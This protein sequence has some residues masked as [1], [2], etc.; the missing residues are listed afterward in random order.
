MQE[1]ISTEPTKSIRQGHPAADVLMATL[2]TMIVV[3]FI[4]GL[5]F[6]TGVSLGA[7]AGFCIAAWNWFRLG[8][9]RKA[10][11][12]VLL[13]FV[14]YFLFPIGYGLLAVL[15]N[16]IFPP[17]PA[18]TEFNFPGVYPP[19]THVLSTPE[20]STLIRPLLIVYCVIVGT[21]VLLYLYRATMRDVPPVETWDDTGKLKRYLPLLS[22]A[23]I[24]SAAIVLA[25]IFVTQI[26]A[27]QLQN[28]IYC[29]VLQLGMKSEEVDAALNKVEPQKQVWAENSFSEKASYYTFVLWDNSRFYTDYNVW[30]WLGYDP[31]NRLVWIGRFWSE[32][33]E[34]YR[35]GYDPIQCPW[36]FYQSVTTR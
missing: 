10:L 12:H 31:N 22:I 28:H 36:T 18:E 8:R 34:P 13:G 29:E 24:S 15:L 1:T 7:F 17:A 3:F 27:A 23:A 2:I 19:D 6:L 16:Q 33:K 21:L 9:R 26:R 32:D 20:I 14:V 30:L 5:S 4:S 25:D 11:A 35:E